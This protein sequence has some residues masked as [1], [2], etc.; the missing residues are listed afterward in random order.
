MEGWVE[1][2]HTV[3]AEFII[4]SVSVMDLRQVSSQILM[5]KFP[6]C[7][8]LNLIYWSVIFSPCTMVY[9]QFKEFSTLPGI[10]V[11]KWEFITFLH[12]CLQ[13]F[14]LKVLHLASKRGFACKDLKTHYVQFVCDCTT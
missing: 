2:L 12:F 6:R 8:L 14:A 10:L 9:M 5:F 1:F 7:N 13:F 3:R 4:N 11:Q